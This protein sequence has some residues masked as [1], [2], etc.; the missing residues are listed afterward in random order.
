MEISFIVRLLLKINYIVIEKGKSHFQ[1]HK[2]CDIEI[3]Y[4]KMHIE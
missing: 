1:Q 3:D 4:W 2:K